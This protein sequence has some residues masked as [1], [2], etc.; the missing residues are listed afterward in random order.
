M[1]G[2]QDE[3]YSLRDLRKLSG[4]TA[5]ELADDT[6]TG[7]SAIRMTEWRHFGSHKVDTV[8]RYVEALGGELRLLAVFDDGS[9]YRIEVDRQG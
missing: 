3:T 9:S 7:V 5:Q 6:A 2:D 4:V 1:C 8:R